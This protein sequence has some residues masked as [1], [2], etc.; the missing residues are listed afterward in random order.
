MVPVYKSILC[1]FSLSGLGCQ[2][3][4]PSE[5]LV[6]WVNSS[7]LG[8]QYGFDRISHYSLCSVIPNVLI[9][10]LVVTRDKAVT[11]V[12]GSG[13][14]GWTWRKLGRSLVYFQEPANSNCT[15][16]FTN[17]FYCLL[18]FFDSF[19][20][21]SLSLI[22]IS[23]WFSLHKMVRNHDMFVLALQLTQGRLSCCYAFLL[24]FYI[25]SLFEL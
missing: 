14:E 13:T 1:H 11:W 25:S 12:P 5:Q 6:H 24:Q 8:P 21:E 23:S 19:S 2:G 20:L 22:F 10:V 9:Y 4:W 7:S 16:G 15:L 17:T 3:R 18:P